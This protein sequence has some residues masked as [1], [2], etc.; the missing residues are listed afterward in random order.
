VLPIK[1]LNSTVRFEAD[2]VKVI[3]VAGF[4]VNMGIEYGYKELLYGRFGVYRGD[5]TL[6]IGLQYK[7]FSMDYA[8]MTHP[9]LDNTNKFSAGY[10]F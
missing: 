10:R 2:V 4:D 9:D 7:R 3:D 6:G 8:F 1:A 5:Y